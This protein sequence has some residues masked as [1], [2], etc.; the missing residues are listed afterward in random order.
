MQFRASLRAGAAIFALVSA[1]AISQAG[2][3]F[4]IADAIQQAVRNYPSIAEATANRRATEAELRQTQ[5]TGLPQVRLEAKAGPERF[6]QNITPPPPGNDRWLHGK[7]ASVVLRQL[8]F[9]GFATVN[10]IWRQAARVDAAAARVLERTELVALDAAEAYINVVRY[11][12]LVTVAQNNVAAHRKIYGNID[13]RYKGGRSGEGDLQQI[14]ERA[15]NAE[16]ILADFRLN[17]DQARATYRKVVGVEPYN[18]RFPGRLPGLPAT[19]DQS[20]AVAVKFNPTIR[21]AQADADAAKYGFD[22]TAGSFAPNVAFEARASTGRDSDTF[23]GDRHDESFKLVASWDIWRSGQDSW[24]RQEAAERWAE[25]SARHATLQRAALE[26][27]DKAWSARTITNERARALAAQID[28]ARRVV[29]TYAKEYDLGQ[30]TLIDLLDS[31]NQFFNAQVSLISLRGVAVFADYQLLA[32]MGQLLA[33]MKM[34][35][36]IE[37]EPIDIRPANLFVMKAAPIRWRLDEPGSEPLNAANPPNAREVT[38]WWP[39]TWGYRA[40]AGPYGN[41]P[42]VSSQALTTTLF[43]SAFETGSAAK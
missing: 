9:D 3:V 18:L 21:A 24:A 38:G 31:Q 29:E 36:P 16:A 25:Q 27:I 20:L 19:R 33:Y 1:G 14:R 6:N 8:L 2:D 22:A 17:L 4:S 26:S 43:S 39:A 23:I 13:A 35:R 12:Q 41:A 7:Q 40:G 10:Q 28:S 11:M 15:E 32:A 30:R 37:A 5:A 34:D 42:V